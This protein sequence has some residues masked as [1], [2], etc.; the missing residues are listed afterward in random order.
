M[1]VRRRCGYGGYH[2]DREG[3]QAAHYRSCRCSLIAAVVLPLAS[4]GSLRQLRWNVAARGDDVAAPAGR[5]TESL[6]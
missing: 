1:A 6:G 4:G 2:H 3:G 5:P